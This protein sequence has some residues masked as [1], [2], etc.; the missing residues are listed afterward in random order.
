MIWGTDL[1][2]ARISSAEEIKIGIIMLLLQ[3]QKRRCYLTANFSYIKK[4]KNTN[5]KFNLIYPH[6]FNA[7]KYIMA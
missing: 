1:D 3:M 5:Q 6:N 4:K 7:L 2:R